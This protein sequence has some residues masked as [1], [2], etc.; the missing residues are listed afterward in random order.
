M[1]DADLRPVLLGPL[2]RRGLRVRRLLAQR[3]VGVRVLVP[4]V[5][6][7]E[8]AVPAGLGLM[9]SRF[10]TEIGDADPK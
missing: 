9:R 5:R 3:R 10:G 7:V 6:G 8:S 4:F 2:P 1:W